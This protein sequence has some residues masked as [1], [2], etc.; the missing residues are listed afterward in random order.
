MS[1]GHAPKLAKALAGDYLYLPNAQ[2]TAIAAA[3]RQV[4]NA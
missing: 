2:G 1:Q 3:A 4:A